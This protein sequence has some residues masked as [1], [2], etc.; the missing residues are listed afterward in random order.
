M[1]IGVI[2]AGVA[3]PSTVIVTCYPPFSCVGNP[4]P[5]LVGPQ[6]SFTGPGPDYIR[7]PDCDT[8]GK[9]EKHGVA[10]VTLLANADA[11]LTWAQGTVYRAEAGK[12]TADRVLTLDIGTGASALRMQVGD[13]FTLTIEDQGYTTTI[14]GP[15]GTLMTIPINADRTVSYRLNTEL[16][17]ERC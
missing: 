15:N 1:N 11:T 8:V 5:F 3:L 17:L 13:K 2:D 10:G 12:W 14:V 4:P 6:Y 16:A 7:T 9:W